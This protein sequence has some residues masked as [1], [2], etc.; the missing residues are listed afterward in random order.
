MVSSYVNFDQISYR[1][2]NRS[3][4]QLYGE[5]E[6][7]AC[8]DTSDLADKVRQGSGCLTHADLYGLGSRVPLCTII[9][10]LI[11]LCK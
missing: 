1:I 9:H 10:S 7:N 4:D 2:D 5:Q 8:V 11:T 3:R 6:Y